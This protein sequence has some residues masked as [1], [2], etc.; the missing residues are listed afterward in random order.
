LPKST[1]K[2]ERCPCGSGKSLATCHGGDRPP[3]VEHFF[4]VDERIDPLLFAH[5]T[6]LLRTLGDACEAIRPVKA[7]GQD[8]LMR[9]ACL[10]LHARKVHRV[11]AAGLTLIRYGQSTQALTLKREQYYSW[12]SFHYYLQNPEQA[13]LF[14]AAQ[15]LRQRDGAAELL[16]LRPELR[17]QRAKLKQLEELTALS[18]AAYIAYP[19]L[20]RPTKKSAASASPKM[21]DWSEPSIA[22]MLRAVVRTWPDEM[23]SQGLTPPP[24]DELEKWIETTS[25]NI[26]LYH[27]DFPSQDIHGTPMA[28]TEELAGSTLDS[29][30]P[31]QL[32]RDDPNGLL[33]IYLWYP[34]GV[35]QALVSK[36][37]PKGFKHRTIKL[38][39]AS[40]KFR[41]RFG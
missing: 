10:V 8:A 13:L 20:Q 40:V 38:A 14:T 36:Y 4:A 41:D 18:D 3:S 5:A 33:Y 19:G 1:T 15:P 17:Q 7:E 34:A 6:L 37:K 23:P 31:I 24:A 12:V 25:R 9:Q 30:G 35:L 27:S 2:P 32:G 11:T 22:A 29:F 21:V 28:I 39:E 26:H 16:E